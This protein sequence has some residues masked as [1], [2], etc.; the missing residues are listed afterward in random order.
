MVRVL[1]YKTAFVTPSDD[2]ILEGIEIAKAEHCV[3]R[4]VYFAP[5]YGYH[6]LDIDAAS[7]LEEC[8]TRIQSPDTVVIEPV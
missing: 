8:K 7:T 6:S 2:E 5:Y 1:E 3:V 4:I